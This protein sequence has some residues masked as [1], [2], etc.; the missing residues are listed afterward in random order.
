MYE[1]DHQ[2]E[3][4]SGDKRAVKVELFDPFEAMFVV[5]APADEFGHLF[6]QEAGDDF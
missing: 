3:G 4:E 1:P 6:E 2:L 5:K